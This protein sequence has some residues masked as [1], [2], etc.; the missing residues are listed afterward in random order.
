MDAT[1]I[2]REQDIAYNASL[3]A[4]IRREE[5]EA[6]ANAAEIRRAEDAVAMAKAE[7]AAEAQLAEDIKSHLSPNSLRRARL[8]HFESGNE[9]RRT[10]CSGVTK[11]GRR[12]NRHANAH[13]STWFCRAH[14]RP[15][16]EA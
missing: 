11:T 2:L 3:A 10:R 5:E 13:G 6:A 1:S 9:E 16:H 7:S 14:R 8:R 4:D 12:C 15:G